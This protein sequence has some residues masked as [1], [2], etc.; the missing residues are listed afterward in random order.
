[1]TRD[2]AWQAGLASIGLILHKLQLVQQL[3]QI[4]SDTVSDSWTDFFNLYPVYS[5]VLFRNLKDKGFKQW[6]A[7]SFTVFDFLQKKKKL[8]YAARWNLSQ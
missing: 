5:K 1:M 2:S 4:M 3:L 7:N 8:D 6:V